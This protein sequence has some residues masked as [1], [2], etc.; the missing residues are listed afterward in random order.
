V[1]HL[2]LASNPSYRVTPEGSEETPLTVDAA[3]AGKCPYPG[4]SAFGVEDAPFFYGREQLTAALVRRL[5]STLSNGG[6]VIVVAPSGAGKSSLLNAG[7]LPAINDGAL[8]VPGVHGWLT[9]ALTPTAHPV[10]QLGERI[11][12]YGGW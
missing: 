12:A 1:D 3:L 6:P 10:Q 9:I 11:A 4:A 2:V 5:R 8:T 7:L